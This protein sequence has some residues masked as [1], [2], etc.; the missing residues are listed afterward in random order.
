MKIEKI[1]SIAPDWENQT[2]GQRIDQAASLLFLHG[3]ITSRQRMAVT[4]K[5]DKQYREG[6]ASG[7]IVQK[8][9]D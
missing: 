1:V 4:T 5:L 3:Y 8:F 9:D 7:K 2:W 6:I